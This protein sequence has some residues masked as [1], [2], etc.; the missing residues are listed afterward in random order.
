MTRAINM[1]SQVKRPDS[2]S[3]ADIA[4]LTRAVENV[5]RKLI[6]LLIGKMSLKKL[7]EMIQVIF[8][9]EAEAS[10]K[11][12][13]PGK[14]VALSNLAVVTGIDTRT[15][16]RIKA[17]DEYQKPFH[18]EKRFLSAITPECSVLD[19]W[20][21]HSKY[22]DPES[23]TPMAL[24]I[25]GPEPSF[26]SLIADSNSTRGVT[27]KSFLQRLQASKSVIVNKSENSVQLI[28]KRYTPFGSE[29]HTEQ[30]RVG[31]AAVGNLVD[32]ITHNLSAPLTGDEAFYQRGCWTHRL[33]KND[34]VRLRRM[35]KKFLLKADEK[36]RQII[37]PFEQ[38]AA[39]KDQLTAGVSLFYFEEESPR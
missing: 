25:K 13:Y 32:T 37:K 36:A 4:I 31:M 39:S 5:F 18:E 24:A 30:A 3:L 10:L 26:E 6:R 27:V 1:E 9:E 12:E 14:N 11:L 16:V 35:V 7:Q 28:D 8:V 19:V 34:R 33:D 17:S 21:S 38:A 2:S 23:G 20:E 22:A 29:D 15:L